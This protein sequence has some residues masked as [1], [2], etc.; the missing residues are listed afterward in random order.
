MLLHSVVAPHQHEE[1][2]VDQDESTQT[3][4]MAH[5]HLQNSL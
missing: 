5:S 2:L 3:P 4:A 1:S